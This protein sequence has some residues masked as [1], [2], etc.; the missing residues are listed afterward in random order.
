MTPGQVVKVSGIQAA[1]PSR[2]AEVIGIPDLVKKPRIL[3]PRGQSVDTHRTGS[4][5]ETVGDRTALGETEAKQ[6]EEVEGASHFESLELRVL[7]GETLHVE[8][9][10]LRF[11]AGSGLRAGATGPNPE[12]VSA[13]AGEEGSAGPRGPAS[14]RGLLPHSGPPAAASVFCFRWSPAL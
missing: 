6:E 13:A 11:S 1:L 2:R 10:P 4:V 7:P 12:R 14:F 9:A 5:S 3:V 8:P